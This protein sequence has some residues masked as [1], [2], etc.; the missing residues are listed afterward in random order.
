VQLRQ[1]ATSRLIGN[2]W[3][4]DSGLNP[5]DKVIVAGVQ[6]VRP[7]MVVKPVEQP[8]TPVST[9]QRSPDQRG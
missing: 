1:L 2:N 6:K 4:V 9:A 3:V 8:M 7:G 5:G